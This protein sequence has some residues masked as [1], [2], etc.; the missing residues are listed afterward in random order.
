[1]NFSLSLLLLSC[2]AIF[3]ADATDIYAETGK[4]GE[5][6][7][8]FFYDKAK[9]S[10]ACDNILFLGVGTAMS[11]TSYDKVATEIASSSGAL[12]VIVDHAA[13]FPVKTSGKGYAKLLNRLV[14]E[15]DSRIPICAAG[16]PDKRKIII[17]GHSASG[18]A[19]SDS[20]DRLD[21]KPDGFVGLDPFRRGGFAGKLDITI[22]SLE[23]G[24]TKTTCFVDVDKAAKSAYE[25]SSKDH[26]ILYR[27]SNPKK[28]LKHCAFADG[29]CPSCNG[30]DDS[31]W[32]RKSVGDSIRVFLQ[33]IASG[34][35]TKSKFDLTLDSVEL[36]AN[37]DEV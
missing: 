12:T 2:V 33:A 24:F 26:R 10:S 36:Y 29:G 22:P 5:G 25:A 16:A 23:W 35:Y 3:A 17:G 8:R 15:I 21:F 1:M 6:R 18:Q 7:Y 4:M 20:I 13:R 9:S 37:A 34:Y 11:V 28:G 14:K 27:V 19:A 32:V 31:S 30:K